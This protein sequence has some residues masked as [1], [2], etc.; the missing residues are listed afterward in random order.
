[1]VGGFVVLAI[2]AVMY[3][4]PTIIAAV[5]GHRQTLAIGALNFLL[6]WSVIGWIGAFVWSLTTPQPQPQT[7]IVHT[8]AP[9]PP[10]G[11]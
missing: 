11:P 1:M 9:P 2:V 3:F 10:Q 4:A 8:S 6:G 5:R 7:V